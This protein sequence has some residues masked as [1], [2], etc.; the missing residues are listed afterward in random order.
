MVGWLKLMLNG[1]IKERRALEN[2]N[3]FSTRSLLVA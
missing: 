2:P 3:P 1:N